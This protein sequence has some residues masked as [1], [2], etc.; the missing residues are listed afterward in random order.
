V[1]EDKALA[2]KAVQA[3]EKQVNE[4]HIHDGEEGENK[5]HITTVERAL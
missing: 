5:S 1:F 2:D 3:V 4:A